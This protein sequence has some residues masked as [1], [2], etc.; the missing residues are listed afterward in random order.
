MMEM[1]NQDKATTG[2]RVAVTT[3]DKGDATAK[4]GSAILSVPPETYAR[5]QRR[6]PE[7]Q[8]YL[9]EDQLARISYVLKIHAALCVIFDNPENLY[10]FM[11]TANYNEGFDDR[12]PLEVIA[13]GDIGAPVM[14]KG[15]TPHG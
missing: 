12:S 13:C 7:W 14:R 9:D 10:G 4:Q 6:D 3:L 5:A 8:A 11:R 1:L 2:L 15:S